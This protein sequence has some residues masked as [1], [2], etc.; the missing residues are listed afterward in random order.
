M[1]FFYSI[2]YQFKH[3]ISFLWKFKLQID[4]KI[5]KQ[6]CRNLHD[7][8][9]LKTNGISDLIRPPVSYVNYRLYY[10]K[11][12]YKMPW[13]VRSEDTY[14]PQNWYRIGQI[15]EWPVYCVKISFSL[16]QY[17]PAPAT[18]DNCLVPFLS[19]PFRLLLSKR[20]RVSSRAP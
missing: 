15:N 5:I 20:G 9:M 1:P 2:S 12:M 18:V 3:I 11:T 16:N 8:T 10:R 13:Y 7:K 17:K 19:F 6:F 4:K 14:Q